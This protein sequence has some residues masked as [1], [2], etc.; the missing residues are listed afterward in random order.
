MISLLLPSRK[1]PEILRR[2]IQSV[3]NTADS[4]V[5]IVVRFDDDDESSMKAA[6]KDGAIVFSGPRLREMTIYWNE[7]YYVSKGKIICQANDDLTMASKGWDTMLEKA[8]AEVPDKIMLCHGSDVF[9]HGSNFGPHAFV[10]RKWVETLHYFIPPYF[11]SDFGDAWINELANMIGRRRFLPF[12]IEHRHFSQGMAEID[13]N[14]ADR[15]QRHREDD[16]D[17]LYYSPAM[18][19]ERQRDAQKL[20]KLM[21]K[22]QDT[23]GWCPP[24]SNIRSAG[25]CP[26]CESLSTVAVG[27]GKFACNCCSH[28]F[29][30]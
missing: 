22:R 16:P 27:V 4:D 10:H 26:R 24:H 18:Q 30:R 7:C 5:E 23:K 6:Q 8:F 2:M 12:N 15:L 1:R 21:D 28:E 20:A 3:R 25:M 17:T 13:E 29:R 19:A 9:G 14:T 11:S